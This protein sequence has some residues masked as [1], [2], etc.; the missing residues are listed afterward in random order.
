MHRIP[1]QDCLLTWKRQISKQTNKPL[2]RN[3]EGSYFINVF[4]SFTVQYWWSFEMGYKTGWISGAI[5]RKKR[6]HCCHSDLSSLYYYTAI[7][8]WLPGT[9]IISHY[10]YEPWLTRPCSHQG[11]TFLFLKKMGWTQPTLVLVKKGNWYPSRPSKNVVRRV[12]GPACTTAM[13]N[14]GYYGKKLS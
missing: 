5:N 8:H 3:A 14:G 4:I 12:L 1:K 2:N 9:M 7:F 13:W 11:R 6:K 10:L